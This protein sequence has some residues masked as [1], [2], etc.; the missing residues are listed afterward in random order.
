MVDDQNE[1]I[2]YL[3]DVIHQTVRGTYVNNTWTAIESSNC[4]SKGWFEYTFS[5]T[6]ITVAA[7]SSRTNR[8]FGVKIDDEPRKNFTG[9]GHYESPILS[10]GPHTIKYFPPKGS[11]A[12]SATLDYLTVTAGKS[13]PLA[14]ST[15]VVDDSDGAIVYAGKWSTESPIPLNFDYSTT[16]YSGTAH[17][18]HS[19]GDTIEYHFNGDS[20]ILY[21]IVANLTSAPQNNITATYVLDGVA[22]EQGI[23]W[24]T[25]EGLPKSQLFRSK[26]L[27]PGEHTLL[28]NIS[29]ISA[30]QAF[31]ID[32]LLYKSTAADLA[33]VSAG[34]NDV[35]ALSPTQART[36]IIVGSVIGSV[37]L[38]GVMF[39]ALSQWLKR[40]KAGADDW[41][42]VGKLKTAQ[43]EESG[44]KLDSRSS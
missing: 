32:F 31:G 12:R 22:T 38:L 11:S 27:P 34:A 18:S 39:L 13:T 8:T 5:G 23:P 26:S 7:S 1:D 2:H 16:L 21:G 6:R 19:V 24:G 25:L 17:W 14:G 10:D 3:C 20:V 30:D 44:T 40:R 15:F 9:N 28:V 36:G 29:Q 41:F 43:I 4:A 33:V 35:P 42:I 37:L